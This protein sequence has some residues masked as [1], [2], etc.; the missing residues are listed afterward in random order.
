MLLKPNSQLSAPGIKE[1]FDHLLWLDS[2]L[3]LC[4]VLREQK[5][6]SFDLINYHTVREGKSAL[7][8]LTV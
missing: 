3:Y 1:A 5:V 6:F 2:D 7:P 4:L 8:V